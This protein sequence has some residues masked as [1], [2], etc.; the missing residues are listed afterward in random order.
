MMPTASRIVLPGGLDAYMEAISR[1]DYDEAIRHV[2]DQILSALPPPDDE[3]ETGPRRQAVGPDGLRAILP[4]TFDAPAVITVAA[5]TGSQWLLEG[6]I[7]SAPARTFVA[8]FTL[9]RNLLVRQLIYRCPL[10]EPPPVDRV[11]ASGAHHDGRAVVERYFECL[12]RSDFAGAVECFSAG[13][14]YSH[15]PYSPGAGRAE[16]RGADEL[17]R[18]FERR[19]PKPNRH[20]VLLVGAQFGANC[21][22]E[23]QSVDQPSGSSFIS[24]FSVDRDG[25]INRYLAVACRPIVPFEHSWRDGRDSG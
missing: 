21:L 7:E 11:A 1:C 13:A 16:F 2:D 15:P 14:L 4:E 19:G 12:D 22:I 3:E 5:G 23:G 10:V 25:L 17:R 20:H 8:S 18:G 9:R 6:R 24:S